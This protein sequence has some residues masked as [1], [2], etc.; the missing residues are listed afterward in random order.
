M[1]LPAK[2]EKSHKLHCS[3]FS[4]SLQAFGIV[5]YVA[6]PQLHET[7]GKAGGMG[8]GMGMGTGMENGNWNLHKKLMT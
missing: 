1:G 8:N 3:S 5:L 6:T 2:T 4:S 7:T